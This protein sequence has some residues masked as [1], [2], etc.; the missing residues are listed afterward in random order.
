MD[1]ETVLSNP[2]ILD[3]P[4]PPSSDENVLPGEQLDQD[5]GGHTIR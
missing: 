4:D 1:K 3:D 2:E 5:E